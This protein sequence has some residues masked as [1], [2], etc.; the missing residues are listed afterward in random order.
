MGG[1]ELT[2]TPAHVA[3]LAVLVLPGSVT[4]RTLVPIRQMNIRV[5]A[6]QRGAKKMTRG[7]GA[8]IHSSIHRLVR[9]RSVTVTA[10]LGNV[11]SNLSARGSI[12]AAG[13][14]RHTVCG[15]PGWTDWRFEVELY[16]R[17]GE[18]KAYVRPV[19]PG[20]NLDIKTP[21]KNVCDRIARLSKSI[22]GWGEVDSMIAYAAMALPDPVYSR[23]ED[24]QAE[25]AALI[26]EMEF[27]RWSIAS[28]L[29]KEFGDD[30]QF[31]KPRPLRAIGETF[32]LEFESNPE[33]NQPGKSRPGKA[34]RRYVKLA[35]YPQ[36]PCSRG[37]YLPEAAYQ[38]F[39]EEYE[40]RLESIKQGPFA[41]CEITL[42]CW[43][44]PYEGELQPGEYI[45]GP[46]VL[47]EAHWT[48][49]KADYQ[50]REPLEPIEPL[51][52]VSPV[53]VIQHITPIIRE[54]EARYP[55]ATVRAKVTN[56]SSP[57]SGYP[58]E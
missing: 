14:L 44:T 1:S 40:P 57:P 58:S 38:K 36:G 10:N 6:A 46:D 48:D 20:G 18:L 51:K 24:L 35:K 11:Y 41:N 56:E 55:G 15:Y 29:G 30:R 31:E 3:R 19:L 49:M 13:T 32:G 16:W 23:D 7:E 17:H 43:R 50:E 34:I 39:K 45:V 26:Y 42:F 12:T 33:T 9:W 8:F 28:T 4:L 27:E 54:F 2:G 21:P 5:H 25:A 37:P 22:Y 52:A 47:I 53:E